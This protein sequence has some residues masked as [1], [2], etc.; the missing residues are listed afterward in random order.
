[1]EPWIEALIARGRVAGVLTFDEVNAAA[2]HVS[3]PDRLAEFVE[4]LESHGI[5]LIDGDQPE[6]EPPPEPQ[7]AVADVPWE[8]HDI[9][10]GNYHRNAAFDK[11]LRDNGVRFTDAVCSF[12]PTGR[13]FD[14]ELIIR[15]EVALAS[16]LALRTLVPVTRM[17]PVIGGSVP[18]AA[19]TTEPELLDPAGRRRAWLNTWRRDRTIPDLELTP[20]MIRA[21][22][23]TNVA[24]AEKV[25][26]TPWTFRE[27]SGVPPEFTGPDSP[28]V[29]SEPDLAQLFANAGP[30][31]ATRQSFGGN[32]EPHA[33]FVRLRLYPTA[34][35]WEVFAYSPYGGWNS[36]PW[37]DEQLTML[38][39]WH[40][41]YGAEMVSLPG[42]WFE[43]FVPRPPRTRHQA[44]RL[45]AEMGS[46]GDETIYY[47]G[48]AQSADQGAAIEFVRTSHYWYFW[49]D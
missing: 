14:A 39:H 2:P 48:G 29:P 35:P 40:A 3:D 28:L 30:F 23:A 17:W 44:Q 1:M 32:D 34:V 4:L 45:I 49:W 31:R 10:G 5:T 6:P 33:P 25:P 36:T 19:F 21:D 26:P 22:A 38:R 9:L 12:E 47:P 24:A 15:G 27:R 13:V 16:W 37:P 11:L 41:E 43:M 46:F 42:D 8:E 7:E 20:E 18:H